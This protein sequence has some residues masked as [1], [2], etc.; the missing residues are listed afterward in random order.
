M[1]LGKSWASPAHTSRVARVPRAPRP[2][3]GMP[4]WRSLST[5]PPPSQ[6]WIV[7][8]QFPGGLWWVSRIKVTQKLHAI[9]NLQD[10]QMAHLSWNM[11]PFRS[12]MKRTTL[13]TAR[14]C[15]ITPGSPAINEFSTSKPWSFDLHSTRLTKEVGSLSARMRQQQPLFTRLIWKKLQVGTWLTSLDS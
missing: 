15:F 10:F 11:T 3:K 4:C 14:L 12:M 7:H 5:T 6:K 13:R 8:P 9:T 2:P 1:H